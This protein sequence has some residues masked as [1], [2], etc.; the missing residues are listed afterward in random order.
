MQTVN[1]TKSLYNFQLHH[2]LHFIEISSAVGVL[3]MRADRKAS[4][5]HGSLIKGKKTLQKRLLRRHDLGITSVSPDG[6]GKVNN[7]QTT[8]GEQRSSDVFTQVTVSWS[9]TY[10]SVYNLLF[11]VS[12]CCFHSHSN[13][14][15]CSLFTLQR[16]QISSW[17]TG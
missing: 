15:A 2:R 5:P 16:T 17:N 14:S 13:R 11:V 10:I 6:K 3:D 7:G 8:V 12:P 4:P 9:G 1:T